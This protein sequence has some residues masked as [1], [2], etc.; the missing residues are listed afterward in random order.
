MC[1]RQYIPPA[2]RPRNPPKRILLEATSLGLVVDPQKA[3]YIVGRIPPPPPVAPDQSAK[4]HNSLTFWWQL[5][6]F[7]P[8]RYY[9]PTMKKERW[10]IPLGARRFI[11]RGGS[12]L[13]ATV[14]E[15]LRDDPTY[16]PSNLPTDMKEE[17]WNACAF[18]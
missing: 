16:K 8:H 11:P 14:K 13:H 5:L 18:R 1:R 9:D 15:K 4:E 6:E 10:R 7:L 3:A 12:V 2:A 17:P